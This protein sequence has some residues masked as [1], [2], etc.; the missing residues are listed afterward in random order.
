MDR[1][2]LASFCTRC[3]TAY[4]S[5][6]GFDAQCASVVHLYA[7]FEMRQLIVLSVC[8]CWQLDGSLV[9]LLSQFA[10]AGKYDLFV[11]LQ[12]VQRTYGIH[13]SPHT[14]NWFACRAAGIARHSTAASA[15]RSLAQPRSET[16]RAL[17]GS[18]AFCHNSGVSASVGLSLELSAAVLLCTALCAAVRA[19][20]CDGGARDH[21]EAYG[22][23][24]R[25]CGE[26]G[27]G[28]ASDTDA[29]VQYVANSCCYE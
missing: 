12:V 19:T 25:E 2:A 22:G 17:R 9:I 1:L 28:N 27:A 4:R 6:S 24:R 10:I 15:E 13:P 8:Y 3:S 7:L 29:V 5:R 20:G 16:G 14:T 11:E 21:G 23:N 18:I 26:D